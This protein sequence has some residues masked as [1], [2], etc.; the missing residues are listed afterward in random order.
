[1]RQ[2]LVSQ[3]YRVG[4]INKETVVDIT[5]R[6]SELTLLDGRRVRLDSEPDIKIYN[7]FRIH[8]AVEV[9][10]GIDPAGVLE[11]VGAAIKSLSRAKDESPG[12]ITVLVMPAISMSEQAERDIESNKANVNY[13][14]SVE[15]IMDDPN[16]KRQYY[17]LL[18]LES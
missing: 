6:V 17:S 9:K 3:L 16:R 13:W 1:M 2:D 8:A 7:D 11:R 4:L 10:G 5:P 14:F 15:E 12:A 18:G